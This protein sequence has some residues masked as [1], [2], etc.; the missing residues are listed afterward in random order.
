M[1]GPEDGD[2][3]GWLGDCVMVWCCGCCSCSY[4]FFF[5]FQFFFGVVGV[6][7]DGAEIFSCIIFFC[8]FFELK[9]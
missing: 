2:V 6:V 1:M 7:C 3:L 4:F 8:L 5:F 9:F